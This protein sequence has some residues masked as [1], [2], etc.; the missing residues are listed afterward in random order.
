MKNLLSLFLKFYAL[1]L[2]TSC[3]KHEEN[4]KKGDINNVLSQRTSAAGN[5]SVQIGMLV[6]PTT[7]D[8]NPTI[9]YLGASPESIRKS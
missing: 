6:F 9:N 3:E 8:F 5:H 2:F 4:V 1:I 7:E